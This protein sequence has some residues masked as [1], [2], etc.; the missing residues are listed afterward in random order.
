MRC[1]VTHRRYRFSTLTGWFRALVAP[2]RRAALV[3][4]RHP[5]HSAIAPL[6]NTHPP[7]RAAGAL[8]DNGTVPVD[9]E[10]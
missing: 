8:P 6:P 4:V 9:R 1:L 7:G 5:L 10:L 2:P 3:V